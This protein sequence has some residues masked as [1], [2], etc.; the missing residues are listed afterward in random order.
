MNLDNVLEIIKKNVSHFFPEEEFIKKYND[1]LNNKRGPLRVKYGA[2]PSRPD[3]HLG[4]YVSLKKI[5]RFTKLG[6]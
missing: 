3:L 2:D 6:I 1:F 4:H 5:K